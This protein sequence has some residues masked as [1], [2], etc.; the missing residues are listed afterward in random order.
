MART[1]Q[2]RQNHKNSNT[3]YLLR[4]FLQRVR[5]KD[6]VCGVSVENMSESGSFDPPPPDQSVTSLLLL[7]A[8]KAD[9]YY[10]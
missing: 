7:R 4:N 2:W 6:S 1:A 10:Y 5:E 8:N 9:H 3:V